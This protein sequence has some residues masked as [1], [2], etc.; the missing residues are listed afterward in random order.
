MIATKDEAIEWFK[1]NYGDEEAEMHTESEMVT[2]F[3]KMNEGYCSAV[4][5]RAEE[6]AYIEDQLE[7][8]NWATSG[9]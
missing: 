5:E 7:L 1:E 9:R 4:F 6:K 8:E 3:K 2:E